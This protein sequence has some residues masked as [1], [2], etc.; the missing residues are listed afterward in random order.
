LDV[1][2][3]FQVSLWRMSAIMTLLV[4]SYVLTDAFPGFSILLG[5]GVLLAIYG[6]IDPG[7]GRGRASELGNHQR[8]S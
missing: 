8:V 6:L 3:R 7:L 1:G 4:A 2:S 5:V